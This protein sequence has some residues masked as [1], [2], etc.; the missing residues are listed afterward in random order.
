MRLLVVH[1]GASYSTH[2]V[3]VGFYAALQ[4]Q[5]HELYAYNLDARIERAGSWLNYCWRKAGKPDPRPT[6]ADMVYRA[7]VEALE[8]ALRFD[9]EGVLVV[10]GMYM[11]PDVLILMQRAGMPTGVI[12]TES[13]YDDG[14]QY[15][16]AETVDACWTNERSSLRRFQFANRNSYY[17]PH[18]YNAEA[19]AAL[20]DLDDVPRHDVVFVGTGFQERIELLSAVDWSGIDFALYGE[21]RMLPS[22]HRLRRYLR[23]G[24][25]DNRVALELYRKAKVGLNLYRTSQGFGRRAPRIVSADSLNPRAYDLAAAG[26]FQISDYRAEVAEVFGDA[27]PTFDSPD[28]LGAL[29]RRYLSDDEARAQLAATARRSVAPH[30]YAA[31]AAQ[32]VS[33]L[34][35]AWQ[36]LAKGA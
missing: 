10:S 19:H 30:T 33:E 36:P 27:V 28:Q 17:L 31:R 16:V 8:R 12:F 18:A 13:P 1:P 15:R 26:A 3:F 20:D 2:D 22:R 9:V 11:H 23:G 25:T 21:W 32:L 5:G 4:A 7:S 35:E 29:I 14:P 6:E 34:R 24:I